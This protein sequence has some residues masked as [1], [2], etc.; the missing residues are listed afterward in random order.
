M[1]NLLVWCLD[2]HIVVSLPDNALV[3]DGSSFVSPSDA[4]YIQLATVTPI[5]YSSQHYPVEEKYNNLLVTQQNIF[6]CKV[7]GTVEATSKTAAVTVTDP[8]NGVCICG[9]TCTGTQ[10]SAIITQGN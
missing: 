4:K 10:I 7:L 1:I 2:Q 6:V 8:T 5:T 9:I 3:F